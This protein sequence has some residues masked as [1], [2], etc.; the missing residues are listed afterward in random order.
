LAL[1][2]ALTGLPDKG[3]DEAGDAVVEGAGED[4][5]TPFGTFVTGPGVTK[6][7]A[8]ALVTVSPSTKAEASRWRMRVAR[9]WFPDRRE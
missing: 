2:E 8:W 9:T 3:A 5:L 4:W 7:S 1:S 6:A